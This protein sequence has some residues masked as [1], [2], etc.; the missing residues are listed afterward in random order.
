MTLNSG[1][2]LLTTADNK[3]TITRFE[4][5]RLQVIPRFS[6]VKMPSTWLAQNLTAV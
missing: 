6:I 3:V 1:I 2:I 4:G 5:D